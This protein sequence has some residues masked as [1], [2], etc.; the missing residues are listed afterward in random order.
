M[1]LQIPFSLDEIL[2]TCQFL[3]RRKRQGHSLL[4]TFAF[5]DTDDGS[6]GCQD[7]AIDDFQRPPLAIIRDIFTGGVRLCYPLLLCIAL[8]ALLM[9][10]RI[11]LGVTGGM[12]D[13]HHLSGAL[14]ITVSVTALAEVARPLR[15]LNLFLALGLMICALVLEGSLL[16]TGVTLLVAALIMVASIP[17]GPVNGDYGNWSRLIF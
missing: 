9:F 3:A 11:L 6:K 5:G 17:R 2:A 1:L 16:V 10:T 15:F 4:R 12:A 13:A 8:G 7:D 14:V